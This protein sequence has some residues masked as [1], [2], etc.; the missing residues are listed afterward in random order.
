MEKI[1]CRDS[2][3]STNPASISAPSLDTPSSLHSS[4][5]HYPP[6]NGDTFQYTPITEVLEFISRPLDYLS[7]REVSYISWKQQMNTH[8]SL[9]NRG[10]P[11]LTEDASAVVV[12][13]SDASHS[14]QNP[15]TSDNRDIPES[16]LCVSPIPL[17]QESNS[18]PL[19]GSISRF[20]NAVKSNRLDDVREAV[21]HSQVMIDG[22]RPIVYAS[23][24]GFDGIVSFFFMLGDSLSVDEFHTV[25]R[26]GQNPSILKTIL[27]HVDVNAKNDLGGCAL[28]FSLVNHNYKMSDYLLTASPDVDI[29]PIDSDGFSMTRAFLYLGDKDVVS[30]MISRGYR[31]DS[32]DDRPL[33][34]TIL[35]MNPSVELVTLILQNSARECAVLEARKVL[36]KLDSSEILSNPIIRNIFRLLKR[37][38][39]K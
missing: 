30:W 5:E 19:E 4:D 36:K 8:D 18:C 29:N 35:G 27:K 15:S 13:E 16:R 39:Y 11:R 9:R 10:T 3:T 24:K 32:P 23:I 2:L 28:F 38:S 20:V 33:E 12:L 14:F 25:A 7:A 22:L 6:M 34:T 37:Y 1:S 21:L 17:R 31:F 26:Y